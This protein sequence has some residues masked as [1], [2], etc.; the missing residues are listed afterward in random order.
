MKVYLRHKIENVIDIKEL[1]ALEYLDFSGKYRDYR[2]SHDFWELCFVESGSLLLM[3][4]L[5]NFQI[6]CGEAILLQPSSEHSYKEINNCKA[7]VVCFECSSQSLKPISNEKFNLSDEQLSSIKIII[8][9][10]K[11][12]FIMNEEEHLEVS[13]KPLFGGQQVIITQLEYFLICAAREF[14]ACENSNI[15][16][17]GEESFYADLVSVII[18][19]FRKNIRNRLSLEKICKKFNCSRSFLCHTF[20]QETGESIMAYFNKMKIE[21]AKNMLIN[22]NVS[23][24]K[25][26]DELGFS[27]VKYFGF[28]FKKLTGFTPLAYRKNYKER[29]EYDD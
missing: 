20:K 10:A 22:S 14:S 12:S 24:T 28:L 27:D 8:N 11:S 2:E 23:A 17:L 3:T 19:Y 6:D 26:S 25:I 16:F 13:E 29:G 9:E 15:I 7:F 4:N 5:E 1:F 21:E 18:K